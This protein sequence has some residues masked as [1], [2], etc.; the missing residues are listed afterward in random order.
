MHNRLWI[1]GILAAT[2]IM[3]L[4]PAAFPASNEAGCVHATAGARYN[5]RHFTSLMRRK[6]AKAERTLIEYNVERVKSR[7]IKPVNDP[8]VC[9]RA[10]LAYGRAVQQDESG[11]KVHILRVGDRFIV[12]DPDFVPDDHH[13]AVTFDSTFAKPLAVVAE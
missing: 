5:Q 10:A 8:V 13:R 4:S 1:A 11:R 3:V 12:M 9:E 7:E 6:D 2:P